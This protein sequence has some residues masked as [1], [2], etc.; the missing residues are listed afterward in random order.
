MSGNNILALLKPKTHKRLL[1]Q[2]R[3][4]NDYDKKSDHLPKNPARFFHRFAD[5]HIDIL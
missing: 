5:P 2:F 3:W 4:N 1:F